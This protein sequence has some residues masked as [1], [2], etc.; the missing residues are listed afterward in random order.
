[1]RKEK[2]NFSWKRKLVDDGCDYVTKEKILDFFQNLERYFWGFSAI[3]V[4]FI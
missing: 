2:E 4:I 1:M 3:G